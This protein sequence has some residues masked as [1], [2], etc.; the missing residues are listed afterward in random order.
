MLGWD[1]AVKELSQPESVDLPEVDATR[2]ERFPSIDER[3]KVYVSNWYLPPCSDQGKVKYKF[4]ASDSAS[5]ATSVWIQEPR[6]L[7]GTNSTEYVVNSTVAADKA[8]FLNRAALKACGR[9][10]IE[11]QRIHVPVLVV[12][13]ASVESKSHLLYI[14]LDHELAFLSAVDP[15]SN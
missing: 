2:R 11:S 5:S 12:I 6:N 8:F 7:I 14:P 10:F 15:L 9:D 1:Y 13:C 3:A 4:I